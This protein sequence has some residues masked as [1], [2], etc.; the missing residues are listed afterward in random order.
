MSRRK[1]TAALLREWQ[2]GRISSGPAFC[3][4][5][6]TALFLAML[7]RFCDFFLCDFVN[8]DQF[9]TNMIRKAPAIAP[10]FFL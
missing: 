10:V 1:K 5:A 8:V 6:G 9:P 4:S 2:S 3:F 7:Y